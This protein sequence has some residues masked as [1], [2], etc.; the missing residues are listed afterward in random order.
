MRVTWEDGSQVAEDTTVNERGEFSVE[1]IVPTAAAVGART[2]SFTALESRYFL[3]ASFT[4]V[5]QETPLPPAPPVPPPPNQA[6]AQAATLNPPAG[7]PGTQVTV[8]GSGWP[9]GDSI[10]VWWDTK[11][12]QTRADGS[13][14]IHVSFTVPADVTAGVYKTDIR[15]AEPGKGGIDVHLPFTVTAPPPASP[16]APGSDFSALNARVTSL[17]FYESGYD[18]L[19]REQQVYAPRFAKDTTRYIHWELNL[20]Y[21]APGRRIEFQITAIYLRDNGTPAW[22]EIHRQTGDAAVE[23]EWT[24]TTHGWGYGFDNPGNWESGSYRVDLYIDGKQ[25]ASAPFAISGSCPQP[26]VTLSASSGKLGDRIPVQGK[27]WLPG[28]S[29]ALTGTGPKTEPEQYDLGTVP[30]PASGAWEHSFIVGGAPPGDY[31]LA[32]KEPE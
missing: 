19:P 6:L 3:T 16:S 15:D 7:P 24:E 14:Q 22:E 25:L 10:A 27:D 18:A 12:A 13:G 29:V 28:G 5:G 11:L 2:I 8:T 4:V 30:V 26:T 32:F 17:R 1:F 23:G 31:A 9:P 21:P 20:Q